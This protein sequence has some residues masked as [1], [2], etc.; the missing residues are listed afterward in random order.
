MGRG[1][2]AVVAGVATVA[3]AGVGVEAC[4]CEWAG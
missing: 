3:G 1:A 4:G 2:D